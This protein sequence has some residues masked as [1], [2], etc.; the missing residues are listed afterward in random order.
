MRILKNKKGSTLIVVLVLSAAR[1]G[2]D[3]LHLQG[4]AL[5]ALGATRVVAVNLLLIDRTRMD[6][7]GALPVM[8]V[9][10]LHHLLARR[11][12]SPSGRV[13]TDITTASIHKKI[14]LG[15]ARA[16]QH[17]QKASGIPAQI[18]CA[19]YPAVRYSGCTNN[20]YRIHIRSVVFLRYMV[21][22]KMYGIQ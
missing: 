20:R 8:G 22:Q 7:V 4:H 12:V 10:A 13:D 19:Y 21:P 18:C 11:R 9:A 14:A 15:I 5:A 17:S 16:A 1:L 6:I 3:D 2:H